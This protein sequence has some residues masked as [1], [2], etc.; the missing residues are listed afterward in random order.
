MNTLLSQ[1]KSGIRN[2]VIAIA[3]LVC[4]VP[5]STLFAQQTMSLGSLQFVLPNSSATLASRTIRMKMAGANLS[6]L[7]YRLVG[8]IAFTQQAIPD[9]S[10]SSFDIYYS[11]TENVAYVTINGQRIT[12]P[13]EL[14]ELQPIV[15]FA[16]SENDVVMTMYGAQY[17][18]I[19]NCE[20]QNILFHPAF[21][22]NIMGLRL[23]QVD[24]MTYLGGNNGLF[25]IFSDDTFCL[26][27]SERSLYRQ[28]EDQLMLNNVCYKES[29]QSAFNRINYILKE[30]N[31][32]TYIYTDINQPI[33]FSVNDRG[34]SFKG[35]PYYQLSTADI[36]EADPLIYYYYTKTIFN[37]LSPFFT[38]EQYKSVEQFFNQPN[39]TDEQK[40]KEL[41]ERI[42][43]GFDAF[44]NPELSKT[45]YSLMAQSF[46]MFV[47]ANDV[48]DELKA[49]PD[50]IRQLNPIVYK[51]VDDI[52]LWSAFFRY[53]KNNYKSKWNQFVTQVNSAKPDA[54]IVQTPIGI[55]DPY[56]NLWF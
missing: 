6:S 37:L 17:G 50:L 5:G 24:A 12:I 28:M 16:D 36:T 11:N 54:P 7:Y 45:F 19:N 29:G 32:N 34:I 55:Y 49:D 52:C 15:N 25:P 53:V 46:P 21:I 41:M 38:E 33:H 40:A 18:M 31:V 42:N 1:L 27:Q 9:F 39:K 43:E 47:S 4:I 14:F 3:A 2:M 10:V 22:D 44:G 8:G 20:S 48:T 13:V 56:E 51:E 30:G 23:L 26:T 35:L